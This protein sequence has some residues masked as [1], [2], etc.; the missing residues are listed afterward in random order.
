MKSDG[1]TVQPSCRAFM[2]LVKDMIPKK[3]LFDQLVDSTNMI[4]NNVSLE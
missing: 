3:S 2:S 4:F 1:L